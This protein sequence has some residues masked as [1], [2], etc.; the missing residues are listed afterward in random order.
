VFARYFANSAYSLELD[1]VGSNEAAPLAN[2]IV[3]FKVV[4][5][6]GEN[7]SV[8][9][10]S[11]MT[12]VDL[13]AKIPLSPSFSPSNVCEYS[14]VGPIVSYLVDPGHMVPVVVNVTA[15]LQTNYIDVVAGYSGNSLQLASES[16][17]YR[18]CVLTV[19]GHEHGHAAGNISAC[20]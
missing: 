12:N 18:R 3:E 20:G 1:Y 7:L 19:H 10:Y 2:F 17:R 13:S 15:I 14:I 4:P 6:S 5:P 16:Y 11:A 9:G 8:F